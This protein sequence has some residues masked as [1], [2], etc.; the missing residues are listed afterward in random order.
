M[1]DHSVDVNGL[2][3]PVNALE[4]YLGRFVTNLVVWNH[5]ETFKISIIGS[6]TPLFYRNRYIL[7][8]SKHQMK[9]VD[10]EDVCLLY[11]DGSNV[12]TSSG[13]RTFNSHEQSKIS[14]AYDIAAFDFTEPIIEHPDLGKKF[15]SLSYF[16]PD[17]TNDHIVA[18]VI[19][20]FP[21]KQQKYQL[22]EKNHVGFVKHISIALPDGQ[23]E[24]EALLRLKYLETLSFDPDGLSGAPAYVVQRVYGKFRVFL[25]G[26]T[27][28]SGKSLSHIL[29]VGLIRTFLDT[30]L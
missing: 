26:M 6:A 11:S 7:V 12:V 27:V 2:L 25:A 8:C 18:F 9:G 24:D 20:G 14:D 3:V 13:Y 4:S 17:T 16:P 19:P 30:F 5:D 28:R 15:Y 1:L 21:S 29:K 10:P 22:A 23:P